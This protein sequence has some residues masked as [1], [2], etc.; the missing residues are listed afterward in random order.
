MC[1]LFHSSP[2]YIN[3]VYPYPPKQLQLRSDAGDF[4][5]ESS[6]KVDLFSNFSFLADLYYFW[7]FCLGL[8]LDNF[9]LNFV[10]RKASLRFTSF[11][12]FNELL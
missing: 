1:C 9:C 7:A 6:G 8:H 12:S 10:L 4:W 5:Q 11:V 3:H 2:F